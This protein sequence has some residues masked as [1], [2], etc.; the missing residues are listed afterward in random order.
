ML[1]QIAQE[2]RVGPTFVN[3]APQFINRTDNHK[4]QSL[5]SRVREVLDE[6]LNLSNPIVGI[7]HV[8]RV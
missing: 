8:V 7:V 4:G 2:A 1:G 6:V 5:R 3:G